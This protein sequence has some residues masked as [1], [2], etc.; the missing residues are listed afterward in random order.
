MELKINYEYTYFIY[1]FAIKENNYKKY[2][3]NLIKNKKFSLKFYD[4]FKDIDLYNYFMPSIRKNIFQDFTFSKQKIEAFR[5]ISISNKYKLL[6]EQDCLIFNYNL[7]DEI[8]GKIEE[9]DGIFF[10]ITKI[11]LVC[12]KSGICFLLFKTHIEETQ[13]YSDLL[14]FNHKFTNINLEKKNL[15]KLEKIKVQTNTFENIER[16]TQIIENISGKKINSKELDIDDNMFLTYSYVCID[17]NDWNKE[18]DFENIKNEFLKLSTVSPSNTNINIDYDKLNMI[19]NS[20]YMKIRIN[21]KGSFLICSS[22]DVNN[23]T[24][25]PN[26]YEREYLYTYLIALHQRYYL[27]KLS[28]EYDNKSNIKKVAEKFIKFTKNI[29][30][31]EVTSEGL[32]QKIYKRCKEKLNLDE[33]YQ[34]VKSKYDTFYK[35]SKIDKSIK[36]NKIIIIL[37]VLST[38]FGLAN[39]ISWLFLKL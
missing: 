36:Q 39:L 18:I 35:E 37:L 1:P 38:L 28:K 12:F 3:T 25:I 14:N 24:K 7:E 22:T 2:V 5:K 17:S 8:Q 13:K 34:E 4:S 23:Y 10:K 20:S 9:K 16:I 30:I 19:T 29:W 26:T 27:K 11:E 32:G 31:N 6:L 21:N 33:L 15:K